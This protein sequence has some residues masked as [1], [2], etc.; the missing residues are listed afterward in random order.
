MTAIND[1]L[2]SPAQVV[3]I[4]E[5]LPAWQQSYSRRLG[6]VDLI[7]VILSV[8]L[9]Q[10]LRFG[11]LPENDLGYRYSNYLLVSVAI[12]V[13]WML[14]LSI[15]HSRSPR[16]IGSGAEE[17]RRVWVGTAAV[18]GGIAIIS[19]L[20]KLE[21]ARGYLVIALPAGIVF[22]GLGRWVARRIVVRAR[23]KYG[24]CITRV[25]VVG[26]A[27][28]V[29]DLSRSLARE[30]WSEYEVVGACISGPLNRTELTVPGVG[31]I[32][33]FGDE[34]NV[35]GA[36]TATN[37]HAVA[38]T[39]TERLDGRG[40]RNL[41]WELEKLNIDLLVAPGVVDVAGPR[42]QMRPVAGLPLIHVEKPQYHGAKRFQKR[43]F[44]IVFSS[45]VLLFGLPVLVA[46]ALAIKLTSKGPIFYRQERIGL[47]GEPFEMIKFRT[48][49]DGADKMRAELAELNE[50]EGGVL[51]KMRSDPRITPVGRFLRKYSLDELPQF[52]NVFKRDMSVVGP[53]PPLAGE[54]KSYDDYAKRR[55]LVRPGIT[56]LWQVSGRSDLSW[57]DSVR[58]D[59]FYVE[60]WSMI[61]DL[62]IAVKTLR[63]VLGHNG[64]Y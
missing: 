1:R 51:F 58:L 55:L 64:A 18:F 22:L 10:W 15:N 24:R 16:I 37:S 27:P 6:A 62:L 52:I 61:S 21:I 11:A 53:R 9:A 63:A 42:L 2:D 57:E 20:F 35:V 59:L 30:E 5:Q 34:T 39:A 33:T 3:P 36:V 56:G 28:A 47:D 54:V 13:L 19:M 17:Y 32:P 46:L 12:A 60:N 49:V 38:I 4:P 26:S 31:T 25:V 45:T 44:D 50:S 41:S 14:A 8:G 23:Q 48:M 43:L 40:I 29:R 7:G